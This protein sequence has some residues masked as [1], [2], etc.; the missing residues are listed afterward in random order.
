MSRITNTEELIRNAP[1]E[2]SKADME[3]LTTTEEAFAPHT[4]E[5]MQ[6]IIAG[7]DTSQLK[8]TP[9]D[10]R[11]YIFWSREIQATFSSVTNFLM[12]KRLHWEKKAN[13]AENRFNYRHSVPFADQSDYRILRND[14]PYAM[15][16]GMVHTVVWLKTS[17]PVDAEGDLTTESRRLIANFIERTFAMHMSQREHA[18]NNIQWSKNRI[19]WQS[20]RALEHIHV[21]LRD[22]DDEFV[23]KLTG[24]GPDDI[25]S[26]SYSASV[27]S[28]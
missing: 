15:S 6:E 2:L 14:W 7:G 9:T 23:T 28:N 21:I 4:W 25:E 17:I 24:Q 8:R 1:F 26:K 5:D 3:V 18:G 10:L 12:K 22:V 16:P 19:K 11:N 13:N 27:D 20:V